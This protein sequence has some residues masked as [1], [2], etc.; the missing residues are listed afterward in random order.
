MIQRIQRG[1]DFWIGY[2]YGVAAVISTSLGQWRG[3]EGLPSTH[4]VLATPRLGTTA[5][6]RLRHADEPVARW[7]SSGPPSCGVLVLFLNREVNEPLGPHKRGVLRG[8][9][10]RKDF[11]R[12]IRGNQV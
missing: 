3:L 8:E 4:R 10:G 1:G 7:Q 12:R 6:G 5:R 2:H 9:A 11:V